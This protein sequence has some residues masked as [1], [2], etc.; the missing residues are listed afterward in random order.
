V[1]SLAAVEKVRATDPAVLE[2]VDV[3][4]G[5][6]L[7]E[8]TA[9]TFAG[10]EGGGR[11][12]LGRRQRPGSVL[13]APASAGLTAGATG[14]HLRRAGDRAALEALRHIRCS[15]PKPFETGT[16]PFV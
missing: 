15:N 12:G 8:Y 6:S 9:L 2:S 10:E 3:A 13:P 4:A 14:P 1:S 11:G 5:L 16:A 7:G